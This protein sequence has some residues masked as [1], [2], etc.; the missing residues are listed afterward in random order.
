VIEL[1]T[2]P[3]LED[4]LGA[5]ALG[6][7]AGEPSELCASDAVDEPEK[8]SIR[9]VCEACPPGTSSS[10]STVDKPSDAS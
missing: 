3:R 5:E 2:T 1:P 8:S 9:A 6:L 7:A 4:E 10:I